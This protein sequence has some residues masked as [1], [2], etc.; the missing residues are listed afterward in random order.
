MGWVGRE[1]ERTLV[2]ISPW[3]ISERDLWVQ[4]HGPRVGKR[5]GGFDGSK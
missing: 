4:V 1:E 2:E 5:Q 3:D